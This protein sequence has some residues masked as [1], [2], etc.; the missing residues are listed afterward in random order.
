MSLPPETVRDQQKRRGNDPRLT[1][2]LDLRQGA[3][4]EAR[5]ADALT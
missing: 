5:A 1:A 4:R 2:A 3:G